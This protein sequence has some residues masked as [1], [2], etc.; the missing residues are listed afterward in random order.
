MLEASR[1]AEVTPPEVRGSAF[2]G[3]LGFIRDSAGPEALTRVI[4]SGGRA[5][6]AV[7]SER[8]RK[9]GWY[10]YAG[11]AAFLEAADR[12]LGSG[13]LRYCVRL[14]REA[15]RRDLNTVFRFFTQFYGAPR[16]IR[17]CSRVWPHYYRNAGRMEAVEW[18]PERT[19]LR[20]HGFARMSPAHCRLM[21]GWMIE[22]MSLIGATVTDGNETRCASRG[23]HVHEYVCRWRKR[24]AE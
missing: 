10:P 19:V 5:A 7:F 2:L 14:G 12:E 9:L 1:S 22:A 17:A 23:D 4:D 24:S 6:R 8:I 13:D 16:L 20:I 18:A 11:Y 3:V 15:S 21:E